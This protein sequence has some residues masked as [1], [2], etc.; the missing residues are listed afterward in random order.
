[1]RSAQRR[2]SPSPHQSMPPPAPAGSRSSPTRAPACRG[3]PLRY[4]TLGR[5]RGVRLADGLAHIIDRAW[6]FGW[7]ACCAAVCVF[8]TQRAAFSKG[9]QHVACMGGF[10]AV[11]GR[12]S[13]EESSLSA[14]EITKWWAHGPT[15][16][17]PASRSTLRYGDTVGLREIK[18]RNTLA[19][20]ELPRRACATRRRA[21]HGRQR[22]CKPV[23]YLDVERDKA[24]RMAEVAMALGDPG[25]WSSGSVPG[26]QPSIYRYRLK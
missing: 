14:S 24:V 4:D 23:L 20:G 6:H 2:G 9:S 3:N 26:R 19:H 15:R 8:S 25:A 5:R 7:C 11:V 18:Q 21:A 16:S 1:M 12:F 10:A 17:I 13:H 22:C